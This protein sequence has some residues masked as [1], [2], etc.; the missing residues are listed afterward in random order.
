MARC[1]F[2]GRPLK[3]PSIFLSGQPIGPKCA[4]AHNIF[5]G[6]AR[7]HAKRQPAMRSPKVDRD[8]QTIDMFEGEAD[9]NH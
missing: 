5:T 7:K 9:G 8:P 6:P 4:Q 1:F 3:S 2:C